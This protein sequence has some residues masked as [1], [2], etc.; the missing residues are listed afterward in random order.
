M[1][2]DCQDTPDPSALDPTRKNLLLLDDCFVG[3]LNK[4][5]V[6]YP[7]G[8]HYNYDTIYIAQNYF[9]LPRHI[10]RENSNFIILFTQD[11]KNLAYIHADHCASDISLLELKQ[12]GH[13]VWCE[14]NNFIT[15]HLTSTPMD[16]RYHQNF[17]RFCFP[18]GCHYIHIVSHH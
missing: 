17:N 8:R 7:R 14:K 11:V 6:Y 10:I 5:E 13:G 16:G 2:D 15:I 18:T 12:F 3:K 4:A 1:Y 9:Q